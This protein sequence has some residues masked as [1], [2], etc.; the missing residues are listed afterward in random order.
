MVISKWL[1]EINVDHRPDE[2]V[3]SAGHSV[4]FVD[5]Y[6]GLSS[7]RSLIRTDVDA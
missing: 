3:S 2:P 1:D 4:Q 7:R 6:L 5:T